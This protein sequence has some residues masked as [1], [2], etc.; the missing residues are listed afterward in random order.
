[1]INIDN[2]AYRSNLKDIC[3][4]EK[5]F[6]TVLTLGVCLWANSIIV[7]LVI[8][9]LMTWISVVKGNTPVADYLKLMLLPITFL[10]LGVV[11]VAIDVT[12][13]PQ[14]ANGYLQIFT[15][16]IGL[17]KAGIA[18]GALLFFRALG[19]VSC[20]YYL[21]LNTPM[22]D[23][24]SALRRLKCPTLFIELMSLIYRYIF[25]LLESA[26]TIKIAQQARLG[27]TNIR[28]S[29][30]SLGTLISMLF[31]RAYKRSDE[32]F[33]AL[34]ARG[35]IGTIHVLEE[36]KAIHWQGLIKAV[37]INGLLVSLNIFI[38]R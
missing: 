13:N 19:A 34:E 30:H 4:F 35:Y 11:A 14:Q 21:V 33:T 17:T 16:Y 27:Y 38:A 7:S 20:L 22:V 28:V 1:M 10:L 36:T 8:L 37:A 2:Y 5:I 23:I 31:I 15:V 3:P 24:L 26:Q 29:Y 18:K 12:G 6:F 32:L 9:G 25:V